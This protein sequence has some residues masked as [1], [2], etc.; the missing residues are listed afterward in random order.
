M[1]LLYIILLLH[2]VLCCTYTCAEKDTNNIE[3]VLNENKLDLLISS[4]IIILLFSLSEF[5]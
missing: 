1:L 4:L 3:Q 5:D 2:I